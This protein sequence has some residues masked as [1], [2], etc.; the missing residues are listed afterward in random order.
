MQN[1][2]AL[3][4]TYYIYIITNKNRTVLYTGVT[5]NLSRRLNEHQENITLHKKT[6]AAR[7]NVCYLV[8]FET[9]S[10]IQD[11]IAREKTIKGWTRAKKLELIR[12]TNPKMEF[13][14]L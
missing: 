12:S 14:I 8:H 3:L 13:L 11:A 6:F 5:N 7:Y 2:S 4:R 1:N 10:W 9:F